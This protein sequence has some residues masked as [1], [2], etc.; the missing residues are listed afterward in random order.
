[1]EDSAH[2]QLG[3]A[4]HNHAVLD[5]FLMTSSITG[6]VGM[7]TESNYCAANYFLDQFA[8]HRR[9]LG[10]PAVSV[11]LGM[12]SE[13]GYLHD[14]PE[15]EA[16]LLRKGIQPLNEDEMLQILDISLS[17]SLRLPHV[18]DN[19]AEAH[20]LTGL[21][22]FLLQK[23]R[24]KGF[25]GTNPVLQDPRAAVIAGAY[26]SQSDL[27]HRNQDSSTPGEVAKA[28]E[29]GEELIDAISYVLKRFGTLVLIPADK[30]EV[31]KPLSLYGLDS[32]LAAEFRSWFFQEF[33]VDVSFF[34]L[35][36]KNTTISSLSQLV[37]R[38]LRGEDP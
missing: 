36:D 19:A 18:Y 38:E 27:A 3:V 26:D 35:L 21:E 25:E 28:L 7:A 30:V 9:S 12:I 14:N 16:L 15:I 33:K 2:K 11:G 29:N 31:K 37:F 32:M 22:P 20:I 8:R 10:L 24:K 1:M 5:F 17:S 34:E 23:L 13:V 6:S 4:L